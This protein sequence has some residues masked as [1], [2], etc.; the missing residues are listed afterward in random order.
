MVIEPR[1]SLMG[2]LR[3]IEFACNSCDPNHENVKH[4]EIETDADAGI[5]Q[6]MQFGQE[7][8]NGETH[9]ASEEDEKDAGSKE[10][11]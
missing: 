4:F 10:S 1:Y 2:V 3:A 6:A 5:D 7:H 9:R 8:A 11:D